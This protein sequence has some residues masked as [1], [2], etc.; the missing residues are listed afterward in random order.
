MW[1]KGEKGKGDKLLD[2]A[3]Y[4]HLFTMISRRA[5]LIAVLSQLC[6]TWMG[7]LSS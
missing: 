7:E 1:G 6:D 4:I 2:T 3:E 5:H